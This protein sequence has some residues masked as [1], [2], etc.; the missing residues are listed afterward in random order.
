MVD[1]ASLLNEVETKAF[2]LKREMVCA[3]FL[4]NDSLFFNFNKYSL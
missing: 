1:S 2:D 4:A 3:P